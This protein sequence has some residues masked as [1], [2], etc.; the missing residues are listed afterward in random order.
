L[1]RGVGLALAL[2]LEPWECFRFVTILAGCAL[3]L[4]AS[5][6]PTRILVSVL[7]GSILISYAT[8]GHSSRWQPTGPQD[9]AAEFVQK[10]ADEIPPKSLIAWPPGE[11]DSL[12]W[13]AG[14]AGTP[15]WKDGGEALFDRVLAMHWLDSMRTL[16]NCDPLS[17]VGASVAGKASEGLA[18]LRSQLRS[19][20]ESQHGKELTQAA[21]AL[22][23]SHC[24]LKKSQLHP[25]M[26]EASGA[27]PDGSGAPKALFE[28]GGWALVVLRPGI[29]PVFDQGSEGQ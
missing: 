8:L 16:C 9:A 18:G 24:V 26:V 21:E 1:A 29:D 27:N 5:R 14:M 4:W 28:L 25:S 15:T 2:Q 3:G 20:W 19:G 6:A 7:S 12:R 10:I 23:A 17:P 22:G 13:K 11:L